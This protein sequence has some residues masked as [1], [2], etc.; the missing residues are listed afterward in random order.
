MENPV[1]H[2]FPKEMEITRQVACNLHE[3]TLR[4]F[5]ITFILD[6]LCE[7]LIASP[8]ECLTKLFQEGS[9]ER[10]GEGLFRIKKKE[11]VVR[12][13]ASFST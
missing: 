10:V 9:V 12:I 11:N 3:F 4:D 1:G 6:M 2:D 13:G 5:I 7:G 8:S